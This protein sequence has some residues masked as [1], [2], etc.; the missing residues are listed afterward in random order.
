MMEGGE[1]GAREGI[2][3]IISHLSGLWPRRRLA[4]GTGVGGEEREVRV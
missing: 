3:G 2:R 1:E 4:R